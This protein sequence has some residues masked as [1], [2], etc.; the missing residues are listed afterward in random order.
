MKN[1][2][3]HIAGCLLLG[4]VAS[5]SDAPDELTSVDYDRLFSPTELE[6]RV[7]N[8]VDVTVSWNTVNKATSY[9]VELYQGTAA[10]ETPMKTDEV[11]DATI[12]YEGLLGETDY[13]V[14]VKALGE[15]IPESK[16]VGATFTTGTEQIFQ[17][18]AND[19]I[20]ATR[21][22]LR[23]PAGETATTITLTPGDIT[24]HITPEDIAAGA[25]TIDG[26]T[27]ETD[28]TAVMKNG[29][30]TRG[31]VSFKTAIDLGGKTP[32]EAGADLVQALE[33]AQDGDQLVLL[34]TS[35]ELGEYALTKSLS[36]AS[37]DRANKAV[38][39]GRF[40]VATAVGSLTLTDLVFDG[41]GETDNL[42]ELTDAAANLGTLTLEG[43][44][45]RNTTKHILYN[46]KK[47]TFG[48]IA[49]NN[50]LIDG[51]AN[52]AGD[53]FD[54]RGG[55]LTALTVTNSTLS[56]GIRSLVRCQVPAAVTFRNCT[57]YNLCTIDDGNNTGLFRVEKD[58]STLTVENCL[59]YGIGLAN[60]NNAN[61]GVWAR[62]DKL[63]AAETY[64]N[65]YYFNCPNLWGNA[66]ADDH[67][68][69]ATEADPKFADAASG[70]FTLGNEDLT[71]RN[72]G[73]PRWIK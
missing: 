51:I 16:W 23:W 29:T 42:L 25:A 28:Y 65:N 9:T 54:L 67:A 5:C 19:D 41:A 14:R 24:Y 68:T 2:L 34:G 69:V 27:P 31:T 17:A 44:E 73:D 8:Q 26:L 18:V 58:G 50:T 20:E 63:K 52:N 59:F 33:A 15:A 47:G 1:Y 37:Y 48:T 71:Y 43:C 39:K 57:F 13:Y 40:T 7:R 11:T 22:T 66:H 72:V 32:V 3:K 60:P 56:N 6:T 35:Y 53:G 21:V 12:T 10:T 61:S 62:A 38:I 45:V 55:A 36:I 30:S 4:A 70:D 49:I 46:N 64:S